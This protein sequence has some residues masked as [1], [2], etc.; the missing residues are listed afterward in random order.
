MK[1]LGLVLG[2]G[3]GLGSYQIGVWKALIEYEIDAMIKSISGT[4]VGVLNACL[5]AQNN[6]DIAEYIWTNEIENKILSKKKIDK[7]N[8][9]ISS[10]GIFSREGLIEIIEKYLNIDIIINYQY[11][12]YATAV[13][14]KNIGAEYFKLNNRSEKEI[15]KIMMAT[16]AIPI[17]FGR[18]RIYDTYYID[19]GVEF[20]KGDNLPIKPLIQE[21]NCDEIIAVNLYKENTV[22]KFD[23][24]KVYEIVP[25]SNIGNFFSGAMDFSL[26]GAKIRIEEGYKD[27]S[28]MLKQIFKMGKTQI[29]N[30]ENTNIMYRDEAD[31]YIENKKLKKKLHKAV[32]NL[33]I[34]NNQ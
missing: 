29:E 34:D 33:K 21:E 8:E 19:G 31:N 4:S 7:N 5:I 30:L 14:L 2:G 9:F 25:S 24:C 17:I 6:Y 1:K 18:Q 20:L 23:N 26:K 15:K 11:P 16:S 22:R 12:I 13:N 32:E 3:G 27:A 10:K 28:E